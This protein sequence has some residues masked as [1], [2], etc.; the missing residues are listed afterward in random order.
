MAADAKIQPFS[1]SPNITAT[2]NAMKQE[3]NDLSVSTQDQV[4]GGAVQPN[5][6]ATQTSIA[7]QQAKVALGMFGAMIADLVRQ[8]G[9]LTMDDIIQYETVGQLDSS[10]PESLKMKYMTFLSKGTEKGKDITNRIVFTDEYMGREM[11]DDETHEAEWDLYEQ[12]GGYDSDQRLYKVNPYKFAR[13]EYSMFVDVDQ[14]LDKSMGATQQKKVLAFNMLSN[15]AIAPFTDQKSVAN[16][17]IEEF[18]PLL[19]EGDPDKFKSKQDPNQA[20]GPV[21]G[22]NPQGPMGGNVVAPQLQTGLQ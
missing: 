21:P 6:T 10:V 19:S 15:P 12:A 9:E 22:G 14:I 16:S 2:Y 13:Y 17:V 11:N 18:G 3:E 20:M 5:V 4:Q 8:I 1:M 7:N